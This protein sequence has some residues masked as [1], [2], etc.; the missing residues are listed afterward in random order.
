MFGRNGRAFSRRI[1][2]TAAWTSAW[3][4]PSSGRLVRAT[5]IRSSSGRAGSIRVIWS[6]VV[7]QRLDHRTGIEPQHL[8]EVGALNAPLLACGDR[9]L[10][11]VGEHVPGPVDL[12]LRDELLA[13]LR[14]PLHQVMAPLH[15]VEGAGVD[16]P[17]LVHAEVGVG[18]LEHGVVLR[19]LDVPVRGSSGPAARPGARRSH[20][21]WR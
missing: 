1:A 2:A 10:L 5:G 11:E 3:C 6:V 9:P 13:Q 20:R 17:V 15:R 21:S 4:E 14:D 7:L 16:P 12:D 19:R 8:R 18:G